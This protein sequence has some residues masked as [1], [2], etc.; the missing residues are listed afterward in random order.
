MMCRTASAS[1]TGHGTDS[2]GKTPRLTCTT[3]VLVPTSKLFDDSILTLA[4]QQTEI[5]F[6]TPL[7][8]NESD[9][10]QAKKYPDWVDV[11]DFCNYERSRS[12]YADH[13]CRPNEKA[14]V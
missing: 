3:P 12:Q 5:P 8:Q 4:T 7:W 1:H 11:T 2:R 6:D 14:Q 9:G 13:K 10:Y